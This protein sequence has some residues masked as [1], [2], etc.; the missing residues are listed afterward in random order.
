MLIRQIRSL[1]GTGTLSYLI[2]SEEDHLGI[3]VDPNVEDLEKTEEL[4]K[5]LDLR[6]THIIDT[7]THADHISGAGELRRITGALTVMHA[8][9]ANKWKFIDKGDKFGIGDTLRVNARIPVDRFV[10]DG[11]VLAVGSLRLNVLFTPGHTDNHISITLDRNVFTGDLLLIGQA[12]RSDLPGGSPEEQFDSLFGK[13]L[14]LPD[15]TRI[16]PGHDYRGAA[17]STLGEER[18]TN[19]F[20]CPRTR[21]EFVE[22]VRDFFPP[23]SE[24]ITGEKVTLQ[25]GVQRVV[26]PGEKIKSITAPE[27]YAM[28]TAGRELFLLDVREPIELVT[29]GAIEGVFNLPVGS[30]K[31]RRDALPGNKDAMIVCVCQSGSRSLEAVHYLRQQGYENVMNLAGGTRSWLGSGYPVVRP[32]PS[33]A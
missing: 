27:L 11:D 26:Q 25:C 1:D 9:T 8:N 13:I 22:F 12:G 19:P 7:H 20:L 14:S 16:Y 21:D 2:A 31:T 18:R 17:F 10:E 15:N 3:I 24:S 5:D 6:I 32:A 29:S 30:L 28:K 33:G 4:M 23:L